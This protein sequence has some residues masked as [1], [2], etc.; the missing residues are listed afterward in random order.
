[1]YESILGRVV[2]CLNIQPNSVFLILLQLSKERLYVRLMQLLIYDSYCRTAKDNPPVTFAVAAC[3][4]QNVDV[5]VLPCFGLTEDSQITA[6]DMWDRMVQVRLFLP[7][8]FIYLDIIF[9]VVLLG[10]SVIV[11]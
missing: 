3:E 10:C 7:I 9:W 2:L 1:M 6:K 5:T 11:I 8:G 4:T